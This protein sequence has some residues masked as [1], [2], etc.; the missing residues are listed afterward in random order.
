MKVETS[1]IPLEENLTSYEI[2]GGLDESKTIMKFWDTNISV[3]IFVGG[4]DDWMKVKNCLV[5]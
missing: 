3:S 5:P 2:V 4:L 1:Y